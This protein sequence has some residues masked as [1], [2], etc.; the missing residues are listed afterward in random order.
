MIFLAGA[1]GGSSFTVKGS[2]A[3]FNT[4]LNGLVYQPMSNFAGSDSLQIAVV[5][6]GDSKSGS[7]S[8]AASRSPRG[9]R[10]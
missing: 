1:N 7:T 3:N 4:A 2:V 8:V 6:N 9:C 5:D 10:R